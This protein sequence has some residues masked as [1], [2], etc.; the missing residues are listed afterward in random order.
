LFIQEESMPPK[1]VLIMA[2][3]RMRSG[4][5]TAGFIMADDPP[6]A[7]PWVRPVKEYGSLL[8]GDMTDAAGRVVRV[9]DVVELALR[10][11]RPAPVHSEDWVTE[12]IRHRPRLVRRLA[13]A[14]WADF[15][16]QQ[17]DPAPD[18]VLRH[19]RRSLCLVQPTSVAAHFLLDRQTGKYEAR[20]TF[21]LSSQPGAALTGPHNLP[22]TDLAWRALGRRWLAEMAAPGDIVRLT[23]DAAA[24]TQTLAADAIFLSLGLSRTYE[25]RIWPLVIGV[26]PTPE[27]TVSIDYE[28]L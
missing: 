26:H 9:G 1:E 18:E 20:L 27:I 7:L 3:T 6:G 17:V 12:F 11:P 21:S 2:M 19:H 23:L 14:E 15:L 22:V 4:I 24:L 25:G 5:C 16:A 13:G 28:Q 8:L 10:R